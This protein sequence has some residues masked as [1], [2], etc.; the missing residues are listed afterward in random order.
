[1]SLLHVKLR[2]PKCQA[3]D[4]WMLQNRRTPLFG[5]KPLKA[6]AATFNSG[7]PPTFLA[8]LAH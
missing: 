8:I 3:P 7:C 2:N 1:L 6:A 4:D 5:A